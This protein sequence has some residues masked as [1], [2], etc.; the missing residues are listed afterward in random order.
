MMRALCLYFL[1]LPHT[2]ASAVQLS[3]KN[4]RIKNPWRFENKTR[5]L[6][7]ETVRKEPSRWD[8]TWSIS[9]TAA[10]GGGRRAAG[11]PDSDRYRGNSL[12][13][14]KKSSTLQA[15]NV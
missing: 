6:W 9:W 8:G 7:T 11:G 5:C 10:V 12:I 14:W 1:P 4:Q 2:A 15:G 3:S 13:A